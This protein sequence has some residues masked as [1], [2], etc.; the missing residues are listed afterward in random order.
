MSSRDGIWGIV[1]AAGTGLRFGGRKQFLHIGESR[2]VDLS[3]RTTASACEGLVLVLPKGCAWE[4]EP[5]TAVVEGGDTRL[6]SA[7]RGLAAVPSSAKIVVIHDAAHPLA[8]ERL[9]MS[10]IKAVQESGIDAALP[11]IPT[12]DTVMR[13]QQM[14]VVETIAREGLVAV[15]TPQ[16]FKADVLRAAHRR[17]GEASDDGMLVQQLGG[18]IR[19]VAGE[20]SNI[21]VATSDDLAIAARLLQGP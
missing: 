20:P 12:K 13:M 19:T 15:Q 8:S 11:V 1:L 14:E 4:G 18:R 7:R 5:V 2:L 6:D 16:A 3:V 21:H 10:L 9:I 17:G